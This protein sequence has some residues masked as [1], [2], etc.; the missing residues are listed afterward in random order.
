M[1]AQIFAMN[2]YR[3]CDL[4]VTEVA[5]YFVEEKKITHNFILRYIPQKR[6]VFPQIKK[7]LLTIISCQRFPFTRVIKDY[8]H[9]FNIISISTVPAGIEC[10]FLI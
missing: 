7:N 5:D 3:T 1:L 8:N 6:K 9:F 2:E 10:R 4:A